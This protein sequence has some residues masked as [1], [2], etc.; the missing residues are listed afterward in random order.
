MGQ[1]KQTGTQNRQQ[2][3]HWFF[4]VKT[5]NR[6]GAVICPKPHGPPEVELG[7]PSDLPF[8]KAPSIG[9]C[10]SL[11]SSQW[12]QPWA[13]SCLFLT[14]L[15]SFLSLFHIAPPQ[16]RDAIV[17]SA[18]R[19]ERANPVLLAPTK[20]PWFSTKSCTCRNQ[21][22]IFRIHR[23]V[24]WFTDY[25]VPASV[26]SLTRQASQIINHLPHDVWSESYS[27]F[28]LLL[29][30][31]YSWRTRPATV[32]KS[33]MWEIG[34]S[35]DRYRSIQWKEDT[36][37]KTFT[38]VQVDSAMNYLIPLRLSFLAENEDNELQMR[39][40]IVCALKTLKCYTN[41]S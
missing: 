24:Q 36:I 13:S 8:S 22:P 37:W 33:P 18:F 21:A 7:F 27:S 23:D 38:K 9:C 20:R 41:S 16:T 34:N 17:A 39:T 1:S 31:F 5:R 29:R 28:C 40:Y 10:S 15:P 2:Y 3:C 11:L 6:E 32:T 26:H 14:F 30:S 4:V 12:S 35:I 25:C 19:Q